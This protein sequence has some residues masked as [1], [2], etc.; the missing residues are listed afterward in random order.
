VYRVPS[1]LDASTL[2][3]ERRAETT[4]DPPTVGVRLDGKMEEP[5]NQREGRASDDDMDRLLEDPAVRTW[6]GEH[7]PELRRSAYGNRLLYQSLAV[8]FVLGL[9]AHIG[10]YVLRAS[11]PGEPLGLLADLLYALG[12]ALWTG[13]VVVL[14]VEVI[15]DVKRRQFERA[16]EIYEATQ[17]E[18]ERSEDAPQKEP[19]PDRRR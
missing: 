5:T 1:V 13:C 8:A 15:T 16:L 6:F 17:R 7:L 11:L 4:S 2:R 12:W 18:R 3:S 14:F 10:G 9:S 19:P